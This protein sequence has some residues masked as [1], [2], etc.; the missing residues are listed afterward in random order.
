MDLVLARFK[1]S[2][3][4]P[5][6]LPLACTKTA[7]APKANLGCK[8]HGSAVT[9]GAPTTPDRKCFVYHSSDEVHNKNERACVACVRTG[10]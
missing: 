3:D 2:E 7:A 8:T 1:E 4:A 9:D 6:L 5:L 10:I